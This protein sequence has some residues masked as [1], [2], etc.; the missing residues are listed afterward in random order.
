MRVSCPPPI[1]TLSMVS[2][3]YASEAS[4]LNV[5]ELQDAITEHNE[6]FIHSLEAK[7]NEIVDTLNKFPE[8]EVLQEVK[9][10]L[11]EKT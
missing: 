4:D 11:N 3:V 10:Y 8:D 7:K 9:Q 6:S 5:A 2:G 1:L